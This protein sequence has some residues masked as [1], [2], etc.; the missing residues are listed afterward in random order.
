MPTLVTADEEEIKRQ[1][2]I[3]NAVHSIKSEDTAKILGLHLEGPFISPD[4]K[5]IHPKE[6]IRK[7]SVSNYKKIEH[8]II[9]L[10]T[11][12][13]ELDRDFELIKYLTE[14]GVTAFAGHS[15]ADYQT[16]TDAAKA[17]LKGIT[18]IF[19]ALAPYHHRKPGIIGAGLTNNDLF[20]EV[21]ADGLH[22]NSV[23]VDLTIRAKPPGKIIFIS[24]SLP[25]NRSNSPS[26]MFA[27]QEI[28][29]NDN[30][31]INLDGT[32]AGST[33]FLDTALKNLTK[34]EL[35]D[36]KSFIQYASKNPSINLEE[37]NI[38]SIEK[39]KKADIVIWDKDF[40]VHTTLLEGKIVFEKDKN[41]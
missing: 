35:G 24:D 16:V 27:G 31:A 8:P 18:H 17:G 15:G 9:R 19:N 6:A 13:P 20:V 7:P 5:G 39:G 25:I 41:C 23:A 3:I 34:W 10:V 32:I 33:I 36:I 22:I 4:Y 37:N 40:N 21:I 11:L 30:I 29:A 26:M 14:K 38:G 12:A 1:I 28:R 2:N